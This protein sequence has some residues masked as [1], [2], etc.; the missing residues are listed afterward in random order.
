M[1]S[2]TRRSPSDGA[3]AD[4][5]SRGASFVEYALLVALIAAATTAATELVNDGTAAKISTVEINVG[6]PPEVL[7]SIPPF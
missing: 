6:D 4:D 7:G 1:R 5:R 2:R 3:G